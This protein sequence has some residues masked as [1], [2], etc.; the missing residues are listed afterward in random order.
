MTAAAFL[1]KNPQPSEDEII[2]AMSNNY[3]RCGTYVRI[4]A[5][6]DHAAKQMVTGV[7]NG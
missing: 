7:N 4:K 6:V 1:D 3:C 2:D 5:A